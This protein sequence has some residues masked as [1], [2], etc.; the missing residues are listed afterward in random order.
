MTLTNPMTEAKSSEEAISGH[1]SRV[2]ARDSVVGAWA[3]LDPDLALNYAAEADRTERRS[4][5][6]GASIGLKDIIDTADQPTAYG[7]TAWERFQPAA[8][9]VAVRRLRAAGAVIMGK[10]TTTEFATYKDRKSVV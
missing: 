3:H 9:A 2:A 7:A 5:L 10:T 4:P 1:L 6:H 8:D